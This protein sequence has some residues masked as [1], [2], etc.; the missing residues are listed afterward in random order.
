MNKKIIYFI[1]MVSCFLIG[2]QK[3]NKKISKLEPIP[4]SVKIE[5]TAYKTTEKIPVKGEFGKISLDNLGNG[6][7]IDS[8]MNKANFR[9]DAFNLKTGDVGRDNKIKETFFGL[10]NE[11]GIISGQFIVNNGNWFVQL[12]MNGITIKQIPAK[13]NYENQFMTLNTKIELIDFKA[14]KALETLNE[15]CYDLHKGKDGVSKTWE[16]VDVIATMKFK[17]ISQNE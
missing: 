11:P 3:A 2:C 17:N 7:T 13:V 12:K 1:L 4:S 10:M 6:S 9:I 15:V 5:W 16:T 8:I 14:L